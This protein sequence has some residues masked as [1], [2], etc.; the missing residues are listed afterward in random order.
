MMLK[1]LLIALLLITAGTTM[2]GTMVAPMPAYAHH[3]PPRRSAAL[4]GRIPDLITLPR[5]GSIFWGSAVSRT[6]T[7]R[8]SH[9][10]EGRAEFLKM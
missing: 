4:G 6:T 7:R 10:R 1:R 2:A 9:I 8:P 3:V 5:R